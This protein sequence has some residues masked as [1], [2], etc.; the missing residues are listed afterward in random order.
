MK[1]ILTAG[2]VLLLAAAPL[3]A[4]KRAETRLYQKALSKPSVEA[5]DKFLKRYPSSVYAA[6][7]LARKDTLLNISPY[8][9]K[10]AREI[11]AELLPAG[12]GALAIA[13]RREAVDRIYAVCLRGEGLGLDQVRIVTF[14]KGADGW[15]QEGVYDAPAADAEGMARRQ[16]VDESTV[17]KIRDTRYLRFNYLMSS[18][19]EGLQTYVAAAY[20]PQTD[21]FGCVSFRG[22][23]IH[24]TGHVPPYHI[25]GRSDEAMLSGMDRPW[26]RL[27]LKDI[28]DNHWLESI[29]ENI[30]LTDAALEWWLQQNPDA[31]T[32]AT[33][34]KFNILQKESSLVEEF[35]KA[36]GKKNSSKYTAAMFDH[37]GYS[38][39]VVYQKADDNY[40]LAW[41]EPEAKD[42]Y[43]DRLLN[44]I[45]FDDANTLAMS[46][47]HG[48]R[49]FKYRLNLT[50]KNLRRN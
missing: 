49:T 26:M 29:P 9:E 47:Y 37:R 17:F 34:L 30:Y 4:Q 31:L 40:V 50:S 46:Y 11:V 13:D 43:R 44:S 25:Y 1:R 5:V 23:P 28:Q 39:I 32:S 8:D 42:H 41:A 3:S 20:A 33:H 15:S 10:Q 35:A 16:F 38:V 48:N 19:D 18:E 45:A 6:E 22:T 7:I 14:R 36:K 12:S 2:L 27:L 24:G 21:E